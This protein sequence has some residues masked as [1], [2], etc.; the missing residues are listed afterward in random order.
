MGGNE[1]VTV[2]TERSTRKSL[3]KI[4]KKEQLKI[5]SIINDIQ[6]CKTIRDIPHNGKL[7]S[8]KDRYKI[9]VGN[10]RTVYKIKSQTE[11]LITSIR[12]RNDVYDKFFGI[13]FSL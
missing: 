2:N 8:T 3:K 1:K 10:Y 6:E 12:H 4:D 5:L 11:I 13:V 9:R 7:K